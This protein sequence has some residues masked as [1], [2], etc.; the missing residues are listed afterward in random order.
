MDRRSV[1]ILLV[2]VAPGCRRAPASPPLRVAA[3]SDLTPAFEQLGRDFQRASGAEVTFSFG[4]SGL[5]AKQLREGAPFDLFAAAN[6]AFVDEAIG[7]GACDATTKRVWARGRIALWSKKGVRA[8]EALADE[9]I[10]RIAVANPAH[11]PY[12]LAAKQA[13]TG[14]NLWSALEPKLVLAENVRQALQFAETGNAD[15]A[16]VAYSLV[17]SGDPSAWT[18]IDDGLH[19]PIDQAL[20]ECTRGANREGGAAFARFLTSAEARGVMERFGF[21][22]PAEPR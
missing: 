5:L 13:L 7:A 21:S 9:R 4:S 1:L 10:H 11:A 3:A 20:V 8:L 15:A 16:I 22:M 18:L 12:G 6:I 14:A 2:L 19:A 17:L